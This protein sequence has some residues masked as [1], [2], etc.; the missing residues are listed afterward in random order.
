MTTFPLLLSFY[1]DDF[2]GSTDVME[3]LA[4]SGL[5]T[6]LFL[7][8]PDANQLRD[9]PGIAAVGVAGESRA[10]P[11]EALEEL[12]RPTFEG[13]RKLGAPVTLYK[14]CS[15][16]DSSPSIGSI[17][18][19]LEIG[20]AVFE[21]Q[22]AAPIAIA[23]PRLGRYLAFGNLYA[24]SGSGSRPYRLD[25]HPTMS[26]HPVTPMDESDL[27]EHLSRQTRL[28]LGLVDL[29]LLSDPGSAYDTQVADG[30]RAVFFDTVEDHHLIEI[31]RAI[32]SLAETS[33]PLFVVGSSAVAYALSSQRVPIDGSVKYELEK[34]ESVSS[35][36]VVSGSCSPVSAAQIRYAVDHGFDEVPLVP[37]QILKASEREDLAVTTAHRLDHGKS[38]VLHTAL[39]PD[40]PR[41]TREQTDVG[42][43]LAELTKRILELSNVRRLV[44][45]GGDTS[46]TVIRR[47]GVH[48]LEAFAESA[49]GSPLCRA[50]AASPPVD[51]LEI[52][53]K[54]GQMGS[55]TTLVDIPL[56]RAQ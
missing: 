23:V 5:R 27:L 29:S 32:W 52:V 11:T 40:D 4:R 13:L 18:R 8:V 36:L 51:G 19:A 22:L 49:P 25:R 14:V 26:R 41:V 33:P 45:V 20:L 12:L 21:G 1:G 38:V 30:A 10:T 39:G 16:F 7:S 37:Q 17:G 2:T 55:L 9:F 42:M 15:T 3:A 34:S 50:Y 28:R 44:V 35:C 24:R 43:V 48:A 31:G 47:L 56:G 46:G 6:V 53:L 54:G